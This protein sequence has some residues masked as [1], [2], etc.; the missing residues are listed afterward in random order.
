[1][2]KIKMYSSKVYTA[3]G[4]RAISNIYENNA[5]QIPAIFISVSEEDKEINDYFQNHEMQTGI[6]SN[7]QGNIELTWSRIIS[8]SYKY[9]D[10]EIKI[11]RPIQYQFIIRFD[12]MSQFSVINQIIKNQLLYLYLNEYGYNDNAILLE[13]PN[14]NEI[15]KVWEGNY[16]KYLIKKLRKE[17]YSKKDAEKRIIKLK[18]LSETN[19]FSDL[20]E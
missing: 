16:K 12:S 20:S 4:T 14:S 17:G 10:L 8:N 15:K 19:L 2:K 5:Q 6:D 9:I 1:M 11:L 3:Q 18:E 13:L 7:Y